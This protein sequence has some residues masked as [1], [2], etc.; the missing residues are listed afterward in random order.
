VIPISNPE[1]HQRSLQVQ[2][3]AG[4]TL[5]RVMQAFVELLTAAIDNPALLD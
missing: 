1:L 2:T 3:M 4:R 5:P